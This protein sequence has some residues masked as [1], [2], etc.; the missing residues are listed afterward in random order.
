MTSITPNFNASPPAPATPT[1]P[2]PS[3]SSLRPEYTVTVRPARTPDELRSTADLFR[4][5][6]AWLDID[7]SFQSF[8]AELASLPG[9]YAPENGGEILL[10]YLNDDEGEGQQ[11][12]GCIALRDITGV[13]D[14]LRLSTQQHRRTGEFKRLYVL[15]TGRSLGVGNALVERA[16]Q[17]ARD[18]GY[19][20]VLLDTLPRMQGALKLYRRH[21]FTETEKYYDT[22]LEGTIFMSR[23]FSMCNEEHA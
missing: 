18:Q 11:P 10:A 5:Y 21:G 8:E 3:G 12:I 6:A 23:S 7:L 16:L 17:V 4:D 14:A 15:P 13:V 2:S 20:E 22:D 19:A 9:K 1:A